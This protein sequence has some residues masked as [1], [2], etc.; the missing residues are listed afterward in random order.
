MSDIDSQNTERLCHHAGSKRG[1][2]VARPT[3]LPPTTPPEPLTQPFLHFHN[4]ISRMLYKWDLR[5]CNI[6]GQAFFLL[7]LIPWRFVQ[8][9]LYQY[10]SFLLLSSILWYEHTTVCLTIYP[11]KHTWAI[12]SVGLLQIKLLKHLCTSSCMDIASSLWNKCSGIQLLG[13][14]V[15]SRSVF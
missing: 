10:F 15:L 1:P 14:M 4:F 11:L 9:I 3:S 2:L 8:V 12:S 7:C 5:V 6:L 13:H